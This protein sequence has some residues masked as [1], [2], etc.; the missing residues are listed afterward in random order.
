MYDD[1]LVRQMEIRE[2]MNQQFTAYI[3]L[4]QCQGKVFIGPK[5]VEQ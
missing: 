5:R 2:V 4:Y 1:A 3:L